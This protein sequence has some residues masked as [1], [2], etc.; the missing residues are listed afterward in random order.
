MVKRKKSGSSKGWQTQNKKIKSGSLKTQFSKVAAGL[1]ILILIILLSGFAV[2]YLIP[3]RETYDLLTEKKQA[4]K[5]PRFELYPTE[6][7]KPKKPVYKPFVKPPGKLPRVAIIIDDIGY[8]HVLADKF[9]ELG[10]VITLSVLPY[11]PFHNRIIN[12]AKKNGI[13]IMLHLPMEPVEYPHVDP[14]KGALFTSMTADELITTLNQDLDSLSCVKGVNNHMG[15]K[16]TT[17]SFQMNQIFSI[18]KKR[19][20]FFIDSRTTHETLCRSS[21][22]LLRIPFAK[23]DVFIDHIQDSGFIRKQIKQLVSIANRQGESVGIAHPHP[24]TYK[25][26]S[27]M[28]PYLQKRVLLV[29]ASKIAHIVG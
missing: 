22:R 27:E 12:N 28:L 5:P 21:A 11:S 20:L 9:I 4:E 3:C 16:M 17:V 2:H 25:V 23:R 6:R 19:E 26:L 10:A 13:E 15:S 18:L 29:P 7:K 8:D 24:E 14:G 1:T